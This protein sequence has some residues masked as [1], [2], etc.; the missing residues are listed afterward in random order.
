MKL[1]GLDYLGI[2][3]FFSDEE[4]LVQKTSREFVD[5]E[6]LPIIDKHFKEGTFPQELVKK[7]GKAAK[8]TKSNITKYFNEIFGTSY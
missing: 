8:L 3:D 4:L 1:I 7:F 2:S 5:N 6:I